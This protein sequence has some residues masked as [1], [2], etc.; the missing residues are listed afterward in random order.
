MPM[1]E[2]EFRFRPVLKLVLHPAIGRMVGILD[3]DPVSRPPAEIGTIAPLR[4]MPSS[5]NLQACFDLGRA[6]INPVL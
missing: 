3:L 4:A 5:P 1:L 6:L 2:N